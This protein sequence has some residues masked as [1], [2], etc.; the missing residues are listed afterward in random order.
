M[1]ETGAAPTEFGHG[2]RHEQARNVFLVHLA[3]GYDLWSP[4]YNGMMLVQVSC[5]G[6]ACFD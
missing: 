1:R 2:A 4:F 6:P 3:A 5:V